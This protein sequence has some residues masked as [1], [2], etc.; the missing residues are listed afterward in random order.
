M[1]HRSTKLENHE[2]A[3]IIYWVLYG[4]MLTILAITE[5]FR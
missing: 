1:T 4:S 5:Y 2:V 3:L